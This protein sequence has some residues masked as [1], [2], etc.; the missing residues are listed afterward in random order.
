MEEGMSNPGVILLAK[1][2]TAWGEFLIG[3]TSAFG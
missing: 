2:K 1:T 3:S